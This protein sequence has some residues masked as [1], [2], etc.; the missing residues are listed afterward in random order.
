M[1]HLGVGCW[2]H[3]ATQG[4]DVTP[5]GAVGSLMATGGRQKHSV[6]ACVSVC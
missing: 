5:V 4:G 3:Q 2:E 1:Q 6:Y